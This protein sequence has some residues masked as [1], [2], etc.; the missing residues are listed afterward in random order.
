MRDVNIG[1]TDGTIF[2]AENYDHLS[3]PERIVE[4][5]AAAAPPE[6]VTG[7]FSY[8]NRLVYRYDIINDLL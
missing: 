7:L 2:D 5:D 3:T 8:H 6:I 4:I 1:I